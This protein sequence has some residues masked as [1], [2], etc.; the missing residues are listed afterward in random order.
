MMSILPWQ[1]TGATS[2]KSGMGSPV[3]AAV[4]SEVDEETS[5]EVDGAVELEV[6]VVVVDDD[7]DAE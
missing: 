3:L 2:P 6:V 1:P 5:L 4:S 7:V